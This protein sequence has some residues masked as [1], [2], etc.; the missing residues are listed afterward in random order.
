MTEKP[1]ERLNY[2]NGQQL[3]ADKLKTE[4][5]Y[6]IRTRRWLNKSLYTAGIASG[7]EVRAIKEGP[8]KDT[9]YVS[10]SPGLALDN[11]G[12]EIILL[13]ETPQEV[14][15]YAGTDATKVEG[16]YLVIEYGEETHGHSQGACSSG[17]PDPS[18]ITG[19]PKFFWV[20]YIPQPGSNQIV[21]A[22]VEL[23]K[24]CTEVSQINNGIRHYIGARSAAS[25]R[26]YA[27]GGV[28]DLDHLN[29]CMIYFHIRGQQPTS[30]TLFLRAEMFSSIYYT[31]MGEHIHELHVNVN[32]LT[33]PEHSHGMPKSVTEKGSSHSHNVSSVTAN[34]DSSVWN[35]VIGSSAAISLA[36]TIA[37]NPLGSATAVGVAELALGIAGVFDPNAALNLTLSPNPFKDR[38]SYDLTNKV[39]M[40]IILD[41]ESDHTHSIPGVTNPFPLQ[42]IPLSGSAIADPSGITDPSKPKYSARYRK[43]PLSFFKKLSIAIDGTDRTS[44]ILSQILD[45]VADSNQ[46][47]RWSNGIGDGTSSHP[48]ADIALDSVPI[49]L[50]FLP[51]VSFGEGEHVITFS[52]KP[53]SNGDANGGKIHYNLYIE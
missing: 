6:H 43:S 17:N 4:Q 13:E 48:I 32:K 11:D 53:L 25:V 36:S 3:G 33:I 38:N 27:L 29:P 39:N 26:Q 42:E 49:R 28:R 51:S 15:S 2:F 20:P 22:Q 35:G 1:L 24:G 12:R 46:K 7:L 5:E 21:L 41:G 50:D 9:P 37:P 44:D 10:V 47:A 14:I 45:Y 34:S 40:S 52:L 31:E 19:K 8:K 18:F 23:A 30:V 16:N